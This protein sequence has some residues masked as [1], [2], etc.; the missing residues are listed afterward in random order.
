MLAKC[1]C[2]WGRWEKVS[3]LQKVTGIPLATG[4]ESQCYKCSAGGSMHNVAESKTQS[5]GLNFERGELTTRFRRD[6]LTQHTPTRYC[7]LPPVYDLICRI[8]TCCALTCRLERSYSRVE[9]IWESFG[10]HTT[11]VESRW[12]HQTNRRLIYVRTNLLLE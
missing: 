8:A 11:A 9:R 4:R 12:F 5:R 2:L 10:H 7:F 3:E 6:S 1:S